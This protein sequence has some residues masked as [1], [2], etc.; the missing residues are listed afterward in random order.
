MMGQGFDLQSVVS[1]NGGD[2]FFYMLSGPTYPNLVKELWVNAFVQ[3][4][5]LEVVIIFVVSSIPITITSTSIVNATN[6][7]D[8]GVTLDMLFWELSFPLHLIFYNLY[9]L[10]KVSNFNSVASVWYQILISNFLPNNK[11]LNSLDIDEK[12]FLLLLNSDLKINLPHVMFEYMK[13][14]LVYFHKGK[15]YFIPSGRI[16]FR[17]LHSTRSRENY[18]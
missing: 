16:M 8:E 17:T 18:G 15:S 6:C 7:K 12:D 14:T 1:R 13:M 5:H 2:D 11:N 9:D 4:L 10:S 3:E